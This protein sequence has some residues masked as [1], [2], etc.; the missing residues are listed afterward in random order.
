LFRNCPEDHETE[1]FEARH[2]KI[3]TLAHDG[4]REYRSRTGLNQC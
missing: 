3:R 4:L 1:I 2:S